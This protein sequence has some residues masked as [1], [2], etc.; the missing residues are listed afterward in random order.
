MADGEWS[1]TLIPVAHPATG[2]QLPGLQQT[3]PAPVATPT[4]GPGR[5]TAHRS[6]TAQATRVGGLTCAVRRPV[7][8][9]PLDGVPAELVA[10]L[11]EQLDIADP[12]CVKSY[13]EREKTR[14]EHLRE[15]R[16]ADR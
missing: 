9:D 5:R 10:Y 4:T 15:I 8:D 12:S 2:G 6:P 14:F 1:W 16:A 11:A 3:R 13:E 7:L